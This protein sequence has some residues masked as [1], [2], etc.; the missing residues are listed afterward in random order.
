[1]IKEEKPKK[2]FNINV[3]EMS[4]AGVQFGHRTFRIHPKIKP[5]LAGARNN[6][7]IIDLEKTAEKLKEALKFINEIIIEEK[8]LLLVGTKIQYKDLVESVAKE[9]GLP[10]VSERWLGG[11]FTNF[12]IIK[13]RIGYFKDLEKKKK[14]GGLEKYTKKERAKIDEQLKEF[15]KKF[16]GIKNLEKLPDIIFVLDMK[17]DEIAIKE[18][19]MKKIK[20][21]AIA[22]TNVNPEL[23]DFP[24]PA[25]DD[26]RSSVQYILEKVKEVILSARQKTPKESLRDPT[27]QAESKKRETEKK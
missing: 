19:R 15:E 23:A 3:D 12:E 25:N 10:F 20:V 5:Y 11:T 4:R 9:G 8:V 22:H 13:K 17:K 16:G 7:H 27:G 26:A 6:I 14:E 1:M 21:I 2:D 18:A 24:I